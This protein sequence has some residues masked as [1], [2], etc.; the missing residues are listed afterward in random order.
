ML[1]LLCLHYEAR[2]IV[3]ICLCDRAV[4]SDDL[5]HLRV[6]IGDLKC[7]ILVRI[8]DDLNKSAAL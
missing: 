1:P 5:E 2:Q 7:A 3:C 8:V 4:R 6:L